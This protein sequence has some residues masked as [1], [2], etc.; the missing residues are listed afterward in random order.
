MLGGAALLVVLMLGV[1]VVVVVMKSSTGEKRRA[2][3][4]TYQV[5]GT[6]RTARVSYKGPTDSDENQDVSLPWS[7]D[8]VVGG[9]VVMAGVTV[10]TL[11]P[12]ATVECRVLANGRQVAHNGPSPMIVSCLGETGNPWPTPT[13]SRYR[14]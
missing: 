13:R 1:V 11:E 7:A 8:V 6:A 12:G 10:T 4:M 14:N 2:V 5:E 9:T 3:T